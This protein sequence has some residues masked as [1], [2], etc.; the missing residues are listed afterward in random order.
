MK[1]IA[2]AF[3]LLLSVTACTG[4]QAP[5]IEPPPL[6]PAVVVVPPVV[7]RPPAKIGLALGGGAAR[8]FAHVGVIKAL[9]AQGIYPDIIV[10]TSAG[11]VVGA[12]SA[13]GLNG[14]QIQE[15][16]MSMEERQVLDGSGLYQCLVETLVTD[17]R[18]CIKGQALQDFINKSVNHRPIEKLNK[19]FAAVATNLS[20]GEMTV[21]RFGNTGMAV[22]ASSSVPVFFQPVT[23]NGQDYVD[24]GL[25]APVPSSVARALGADFV[26]A[27]DISERP[28]DRSTA[29]ITDILWQ[30]FSIFVR[31]INHHEQS[32][33]D[34]VVRPVTLG[35]PSA[36]VS[37]VNKAVLEGEKAVA[38]IL[39]E[40][41]ARLAI[42]NERR[43]VP[44]M[45]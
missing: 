14:F 37:G 4:M 25:V 3:L 33:A 28:E 15:L 22:R 32:R 24:G 45:P 2:Y 11:S 31:T 23:I 35:L 29:G 38:K 43:H 5:P 40:L 17:K 18:G 8:G 19:T 41:K 44:G 9:E 42:L 12:R 26:I 16:S 36:S 30:T 1:K 6:A 39:P 21:F 27:V 20:T 7:E 13:S 34:I 10:G